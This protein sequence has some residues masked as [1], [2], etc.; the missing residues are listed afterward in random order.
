MIVYGH[1]HVPSIVRD[2]PRMLVNPGSPTWKR[3]QPYP[4]VAVARLAPGSVAVE[5]VELREFAAVGR[6]G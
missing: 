4:T 1:S 3:R 5:P 6:S 2:G